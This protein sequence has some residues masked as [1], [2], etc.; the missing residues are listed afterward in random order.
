MFRAC[1]VPNGSK[2]MSRRCW[3]LASG[4]PRA[5]RALGTRGLR[6]PVVTK[7]AGLRYLTAQDVVACMPTVDEAIAIAE[8]T[9]TSLIADAVVPAKTVIPLDRSGGF[10]HAMPAYKPPT[11]SIA[12]RLGV[13]WV[14]GLPG[15]LAD[16]GGSIHGTVLL[17]D[18]RD[19]TLRAILDGG[20]ITAARTA[21][22]SGVAIRRWAPLLAGRTYR[23]ALIGAGVQARQHL[24]VLGRL[25]P[26]L[27]LL[28]HDRH[29]DR[30]AAIV[31]LARATSGIADAQAVPSIQAAVDGAD[32]V[33]TAVS[34]GADR[35]L[36][37]SSWLAPWALL[38]PVDYDMC[39]SAEVA[40]AADLFLVD[41]ASQLT[42][43]RKAG[44]FVG[45]RE[46]DM[47]FG[48]AMLASLPRPPGLVVAAHLGV[49]LA[50]VM[51]GSAIL[52][53]AE[54]RGLGQPLPR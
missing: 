38:V 26:D 31:S 11:G 53:R 21:A 6:D 45:F 5:R 15:R 50:D 33:V 47:T 14:V 49:G 9:L 29:D 20:P 32:V 40:R 30:A 39:C 7:S 10:A 17:T 16:D 48:A 44:S 41:E 2:R 1:A 46:P 28:V 34:F 35:Q 42:D 25:L 13:K 18:L 12:G 22:I 8:A 43:A 23:V 4:D 36:I 54:E 51:F 27:Q 19:G 24:A 52:D 3:C 37:Q